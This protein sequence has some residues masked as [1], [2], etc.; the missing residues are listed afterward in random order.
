MSEKEVVR[1]ERGEVGTATASLTVK[2]L[3][4]R[5]CFVK[6]EDKLVRKPDAVSLKQ[7]ARTLLKQDDGSQVAKSW[8]AHKAGSLNKGRSEN[9]LKR[10]GLEKAA[11]KSARRGKK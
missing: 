1:G 10:I 6:D 9:S 4:H 8:F 2:Q 3:W 7:F 11:T 5:A